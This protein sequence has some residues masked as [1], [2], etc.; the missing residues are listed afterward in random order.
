MKIFF[1][2]LEFWSVCIWF[3]SGIIIVIAVLDNYGFSLIDFS[4]VVHEI[5]PSYLP[6]RANITKSQSRNY[7]ETQ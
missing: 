6:S 2:F 1:L 3:L 7:S 4:G 5:I